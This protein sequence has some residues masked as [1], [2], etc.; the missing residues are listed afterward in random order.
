MFRRIPLGGVGEHDGGEVLKV[1][2]DAVEEDHAEQHAAGQRT[3]ERRESM[4][5]DFGP[6]APG[7][8]QQEAQEDQQDVDEQGQETQSPDE[9]CPAT[10]RWWAGDDRE[11][12]KRSRHPS[13]ACNVTTGSSPPPPL[14]KNWD[15]P[16]SR[17]VS[18]RAVPLARNGGALLARTLRHDGRRL[19][20][21]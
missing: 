14:H 15:K 12:G 7:Q 10:K 20:K 3:Q 16:K 18:G 2:G 5:P 8:V 9:G 6:T 13:Q 4:D 1:P 19:P 17:Q 21:R 11:V